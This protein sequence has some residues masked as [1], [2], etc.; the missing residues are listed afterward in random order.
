MENSK[1]INELV[2]LNR[3][4]V[5]DYICCN[6]HVIVFRKPSASALIAHSNAIIVISQVS[7]HPTRI[8][9]IIDLEQKQSWSY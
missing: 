1:I 4:I 2:N 3:N 7:C 5:E 6:P 8:N 9:S